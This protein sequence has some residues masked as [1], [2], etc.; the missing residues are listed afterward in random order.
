MRDLSNEMLCMKHVKFKFKIRLKFAAA[1][2]VIKRITKFVQKQVMINLD[3]FNLL[4]LRSILTSAVRRP[5][6][7]TTHTL[8]IR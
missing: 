7:C 2:Q 8:K 5:S 1:T 4:H 6:K 3:D